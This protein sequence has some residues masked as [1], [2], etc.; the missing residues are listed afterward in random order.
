MEKEELFIPTVQEWIEV[1]MRRSMRNFIQYSKENGLSMTQLGA[2]FQ[3]R[4]KGAADVS[5][6]GDH[7][8][9]TSAAASQMLDRLVQQ[10]LVIRSEDP[11]DRRVK[12]IALT[13]KGLFAL[14]ESTNARQMWLK[15]M[16][17]VLTSGEKEQVVAALEI[18][19]QKA[20][21]LDEVSEQEA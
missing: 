12:N 18:M 20:R 17:K 8:G 14:Q 19:I 1:F 16:D 5:S 4:R 6:I 11:N 13:D 21:Q 2:L 15:E 7:L 3:L 9:I 10:R